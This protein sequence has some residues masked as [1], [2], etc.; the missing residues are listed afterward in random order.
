MEL[1]GNREMTG[2]KK[3][4][5]IIGSSLILLFVWPFFALSQT[6]LQYQ[7]RGNRYEGIKPKPVTGL[8]IELISFLVDYKEEIDQIPDKLKI[9]FY[10]EKP[11]NKVHLIV[12][13][14]D[15]KHY[16][17]LDKV[18]PKVPWQKGFYNVFEWPTK[19]VIK[20]LDNIKMHD[21]GVIARLE[22]KEPSMSEKVAPVVFYHSQPP[23]T[24]KGYLFT[25]KTNG[26]AYLNCSVYKQGKA[27]PVFTQVF[28]RK[29]GGRPFTVRWK[30]TQ[31]DEGS[32]RLVVNGHFLQN[33]D[34]INQEVR[35]YHNPIVK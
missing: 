32:Y 31:D 2:Y 26:D 5:E 28:N 6:H 18:Q 24:I 20:R 8:D 29:K 22:K 23:T 1:E 34:P 4:L 11:Y 12:R 16:Y 10:L 9:K 33:N 7:D 15:Y 13:E 21:L 3:I 19:D 25:L 17:W 27:E 30:S 14:L 35:F